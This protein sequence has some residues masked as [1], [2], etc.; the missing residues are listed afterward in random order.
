MHFDLFI[1][2]VAEYLGLKKPF[3]ILLSSRDGK[4]AAWHLPVY[5]RNGKLKS[6]KIT[7][8]FVNLQTDDR[9]LKTLVAHEMIHAWQEENGHMAEYHGPQF[10]NMAAG[11]SRK[12]PSLKGIY[13]PELDQ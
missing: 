9:N 11:L 6:H 2:A 10:Q 3:D 8:N 13:D 5:T 7:I 4:Y 1:R 12:F